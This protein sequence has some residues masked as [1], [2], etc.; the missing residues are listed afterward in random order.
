M[1]DTLT[2]VV[3]VLSGAIG[4]GYFVYGKRQNDEYSLGPGYT[5]ADSGFISWPFRISIRLYNGLTGIEGSYL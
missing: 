3:Y 2:F 4:L 1:D 5:L